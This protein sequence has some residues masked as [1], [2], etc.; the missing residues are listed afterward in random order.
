MAARDIQAGRAHVLLAIRDKMTQGLKLAEKKLKNFG[1][2]WATTGGVAAAATG[3]AMA[4]P[5]KL[6][7]DMERT[8]TAFA[9]LLG[10]ADLA[11]E[12]IAAIDKMGAQTPFTFDHLK[13]AA[14]MLL[15][16]G[17]SADAL[18]PTLRD[19]GDVS[20]GDPEKLQR[21]ALAFGQVMAKGRLMGQ[22]VL[23]MTEN[24]FN[25][26]MEIS[27]T[28]GVSVADLSKKMENGEISAAVLSGAF[29]S[30]ASEGGRYFG[31]MDKQSKTLFGLFSTMQDYAA[32]LARELGNILVPTLKSFA[33]IAIALATVVTQWIK[34]NADL[35]STIGKVALGLFTLSAIAVG[36]GSVFLGVSFLIG[37]LASAVGALG[38]VFGLLFSPLGVVLALMAGVIAVAIVYRDTLA[39]MFAPVLAWLQPV[40]DMFR[41]IYATFLEAYT[42]IVDALQ[43]GN[44]EAAGT[45]AFNGLMTVIFTAL[46][47]IFGSVL[48]WT[49]SIGKSI[50]NGRWDLAAAIALA[51][52]RLA[53]LSAWNGIADV[54]DMGVST[55]QSVWQTIT[56]TMRWTFRS[57]VQGIAQ[58]IV[59]LGQRFYDLL[60]YLAPVWEYLGQGELFRGIRESLNLNGVSEQLTQMHQQQ[61]AEDRRASQAQ[62]LQRDAATAENMAR[63]I[64]AEQKIAAEIVGYREEANR[65][66]EKSGIASF[67]DRARKAQAEMRNAI[68]AERQEAASKQASAK[69]ASKGALAGANSSTPSNNGPGTSGTFNAY[70]SMLVGLGRSNAEA[71]TAKNTGELV[72]LAREQNL[73]QPAGMGA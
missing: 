33:E 11:K 28:T 16:F 39:A 21:L 50:L 63:R 40:V 23:Q 58:S 12:K 70:A 60:G 1:M 73:K 64:A 24:G 4:W 10:N 27:R 18:L 51:N 37:V 17:V 5:I 46:D 6:A 7:A 2:M 68:A 25:P 72:K 34:R 41:S 44:I 47:T 22:E 55:M 66:A 15:G 57:M 54:W 38:A 48:E 29:R 14:Q 59:W 62:A 56:D 61:L 26:L 67:G 49:G 13:D 65:E 69:E 30:A 42:G 32:I 19:L 8:D 52:V 45:I 9:V 35:V 71:T 53:F 36:I 20:Q 31:M 3:G 43:A